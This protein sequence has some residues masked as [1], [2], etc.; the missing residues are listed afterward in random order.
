MAQILTLISDYRI[1]WLSYLHLIDISFWLCW[2]I[3]QDQP[4]RVGSQLLSNIL[5]SEMKYT[6]PKIIHEIYL[7][8]WQS[9]YIYLWCVAS[10]PRW[11][12]YTLIQYWVQLFLQT[13]HC[14]WVQKKI[15]IQAPV[16]YTYS[17]NWRH[18]F[19]TI[20]FVC[21][22]TKW[23]QADPTEREAAISGV[24]LQL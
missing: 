5:Q 13:I 6:R 14:V 18:I 1:G 9:Q 10:L 2:L 21:I 15:Q 16:G 3:L 17:I 4:Q 22:L 23:Y 24:E 20:I 12:G 8:K 19:Y 11:I 7:T